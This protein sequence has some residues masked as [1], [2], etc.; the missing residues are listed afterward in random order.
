MVMME[1]CEDEKEKSRHDS[2]IQR[3]AEDLRRPLNEIDALY[4]GALREMK[5]T[6]RVKDYLIILASRQVKDRL[7]GPSRAA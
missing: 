4:E 7:L 5:K 2:A 3:L 6:A 1:V